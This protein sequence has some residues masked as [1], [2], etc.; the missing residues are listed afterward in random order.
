M[1]LQLF[2]DETNIKV[3]VFSVITRY[4]I[5]SQKSNST[6]QLFQHSTIMKKIFDDVFCLYY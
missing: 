3:K 2:N 1:E 5:E 6:K 4:I